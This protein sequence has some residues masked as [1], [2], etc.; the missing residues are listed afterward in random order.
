MS[1]EAGQK[2]RH[3][4]TGEVM[5]VTHVGLIGVRLPNLETA[6]VSEEEVEIIEATEAE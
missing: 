1:I 5:L 6:I 2:V 4:L 3:R